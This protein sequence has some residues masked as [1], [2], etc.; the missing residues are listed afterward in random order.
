MT[1]GYRLKNGLTPKMEHF[2]QMVARGEP[3]LIAD[4]YETA[5]DAENMKRDSVYTS[6]SEL[7]ANPKITSRI[8]EIR[9]ALQR[10]KEITAESLVEELD[11]AREV[12]KERKSAAAMVG[13]TMGKAKITGHVVDK[14]ERTVRDE[15][16]QTGPSVG[17][18]LEQSK[19]SGQPVV[20]QPVDDKE[21]TGPT[22]SLTH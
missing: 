2:A 7:L 9:Q 13:A 15:R 5:Y 10:A 8:D 1:Q 19:P 3:K 11:E 21:Q 16:P 14:Q 18:L 12:A 20:P 17:E 4:C 6:A 22:S